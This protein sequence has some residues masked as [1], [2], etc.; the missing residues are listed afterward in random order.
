MDEFTIEYESFFMDDEPKH[1]VFDLD[2][3]YV[4]FIASAI[5]VCDTSIF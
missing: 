3:C 5:S 1:D 4:D 2:M